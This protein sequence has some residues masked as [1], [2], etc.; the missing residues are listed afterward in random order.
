MYHTSLAHPPNAQS[1]YKR[2]MKKKLF[3][4]LASI[5]LVFQS[6]KGLSLV[7]ALETDSWSILLLIAWLCNLFITGIFAFAGFAFPTERLMPSKY[8]RIQ[9]PEKLRWWYSTL[10]VDWFRKILLA[11]LWRSQR[12]RATFFNGKKAGIAHMVTQTQKAEFGHFIPFVLIILS[13]IYFVVL[14]QYQ[15]AIFTVFINIIGNFYPIVLQRHHR[16]RIERLL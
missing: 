5:F 9:S 11:T 12:Q 3:L 8:Y 7:H 15:L 16:M 6:I 14:G 13:S 2:T 4:S 10:K 1:P